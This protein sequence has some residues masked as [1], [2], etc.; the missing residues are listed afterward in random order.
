MKKKHLFLGVAAALITGVACRPV[1]KKSGEVT[2]IPVEEAL[3]QHAPLSLKEDIEKIEYIPLET[4]DSCLV[5]NILDLAITAEYLFVYQGKENKVYQF[6]RDGKFIRQISETGNGPEEIMQVAALAADEP[7]RKLSIFQLDGN[8]SDFSFDGEFLGRHDTWK[9]A[10][11]MQ[12]LPDGKKALKG[13]W[14]TPLVNAPWLAALSD[15]NGNLK[16]SK[17]VYDAK[18]DSAAFFMQEIAF[19][20]VADGVLSFTNYNDTVY[21]VTSSGI[22]PAYALKRGNTDE[23]Y[24]IVADIG[25]NRGGNVPENSI[26]VYDFFETPAN[27]YVRAERNGEFYIIQYRKATGETRSHRLPEAY[28]EAS[29]QIPGQNCM[30][31]DN[32][33]DGGVPVWPEYGSI[34]HGLYAQVITADILS[35]LKAGGYIKN[36]PA[37]LEIGEDD[38]PVI[39]VYHLKAEEK[40]R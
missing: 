39:I 3:R 29:A 25:R 19:V 26:N 1:D 5:S 15:S 34:R 21:R 31:I 28:L 11:G 38:N 9:Q 37:A 6:G 33:I 36:P 18:I 27:F 4:N 30:G 7:N 40:K 2:D 12:T 8:V 13:R 35:S 32:D 24:S 17:S 14:Y 20:P 16:D 23:Y 22:R 10:S